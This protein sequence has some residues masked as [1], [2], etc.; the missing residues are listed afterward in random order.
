MGFTPTSVACTS[1]ELN[2]DTPNPAKYQDTKKGVEAKK[3]TL[4]HNVNSKDALIS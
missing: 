4:I 1:P 2:E 3:N